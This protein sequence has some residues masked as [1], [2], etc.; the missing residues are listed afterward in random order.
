V[1]R[2]IGFRARTK[3]QQRR[4]LVDRLTLYNYRANAHLYWPEIHGAELW[5]AGI[6]MALLRGHS[7]FLPFV[8]RHAH[9][10]RRIRRPKTLL[11]SDR[12][13]VLHVTCSFDLGGT[14]TQIRNLCTALAPAFV[15]EAVETFPEVNYLFRRGVEIDAGRYVRGNIVTRTLG[16]LTVSPS[17]R[18]AQLVQVYK[19]VRDFEAERP[20]V[21]VGWGH[22]IAMLTFVAA[23]IA[24]VPHIVFCIRTFNPA[25]GWVAEPMGELLHTAHTRMFAD[26]AK[27][28]VNST[29]LQR[30]YAEWLGINPAAIAVCPNGIDIAPMDANEAAAH[31]AAIRA[32][33][34]IA[35]D[36]VVLINVGRFSREKGQMSLVR[37]NLALLQERG[38]A[39]FHWL[40]CGDGPTLDEVRAFAD[41]HGMTNVTFAGRT[42]E[43]R[44][45]LSASDVFVMPSD[46]E[47]MPNAMMEAMTH[48]LPCVSTTR[49][50]ALDVA[51]DG[52]EALYYEPRDVEALTGHLRRLIANADERQRLGCHARERMREF[53]VR[54]FVENFEATLEAVMP[55][56]S[57]HP[58]PEELPVNPY[59]LDFDPSKHDTATRL[60]I[61]ESSVAYLLDEV[62]SLRSIV[63]HLVADR[64]ES[65]PAIGQ[66][67]ESFD[68]QW[69]SLPEG[70][71]MLSNPEWKAAVPRQI[72][73]FA[74]LPVEWFR[75]KSVVDAGCGQGRWTYGFGRLDVGRCVSFDISENG[76]QRTQE[77]AK[78]FGDR[79]QVLRKN[80]LQPLDLPQEFDL[81]WCFGVLHHTGD[82]Y[83]GFQH[84]AQLVKPGG[85][86]FVMIYGE[87]KRGYADDYGYYH[88]LF[89]MRAGLRNLRFEDKVAAIERR[90]G[91]ELLHGYFDAISPE[92]NDLYR[93]D[94][95]VSWFT[96][97]GFEDM[98][99]TDP[100]TNH[101]MIGRKKA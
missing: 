12:L 95:L 39:A 69:R 80:I 47:G 8:C 81:V 33:Y 55:P 91:K 84:L 20:D 72:S 60:H 18:S 67:R 53:S 57:I 26:V 90:Y 4:S 2:L 83:R 99:R 71:S 11:L 41:T 56:P 49:S 3:L 44:A 62:S 77:I 21:V 79:I 16:R 6:A 10:L 58:K 75:G 85:Y 98:K 78:E 37:A 13:K 28:V 93:W 51:R 59:P 70:K 82:T 7:L 74:D 61:L 22:E 101:H 89:A 5:A 24:R 34:G 9:W 52:R 54:R 63:R 86:L 30:D 42:S 46:F 38:G 25:Y 15:H 96:D 35:D 92:I 23:A 29:P 31:R 19:L 50:G 45:F 73:T 36:T 87:P 68:Y 48:G 76:V 66:T 27:V 94:E 97:A 17:T 65:L 1:K 64:A 43:V 14:Q 40:L 88:D 32:Q 100:G